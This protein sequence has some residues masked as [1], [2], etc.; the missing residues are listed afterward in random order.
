[1]YTAQEGRSMASIGSHRLIIMRYIVTDR[2]TGERARRVPHRCGPTGEQYPLAARTGCAP[3]ATRCRRRALAA[4]PACVARVAAPTARARAR[5]RTHARLLRRRAAAA[6]PRRHGLLTTAVR[7]PR[8]RRL[9]F[10]RLRVAGVPSRSLG[11][12]C[13]GEV[14]KQVCYQNSASVCIVVRVCDP[15]CMVDLR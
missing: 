13:M 6:L 3:H 10:R 9:L 14:I 15:N 1:M 11:A 5:A 8:I 12:N 7:L 2:P 4:Q